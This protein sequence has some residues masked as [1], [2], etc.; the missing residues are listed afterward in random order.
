[1]SNGYEPKSEVKKRKKE[2][3]RAAILDLVD[4][5]WGTEAGSDD[6]GSSDGSYASKSGQTMSKPTSKASYSKTVKVKAKPKPGSSRPGR[7]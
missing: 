2:G 3:G 1:M 6:S 5:E 4:A 7:P